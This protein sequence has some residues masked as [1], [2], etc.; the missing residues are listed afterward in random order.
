MGKWLAVVVWGL[1][2]VWWVDAEVWAAHYAITEPKCETVYL[3]HPD[4][5]RLV[6]VVNTCAPADT[7]VLRR[8]SRTTHYEQWLDRRDSILSGTRA[9]ARR[10]SL[11]S[12]RQ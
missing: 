6:R 12:P 9:R 8:A 10:D 7:V 5:R 2:C 3:H 4:P 11:R 1:L